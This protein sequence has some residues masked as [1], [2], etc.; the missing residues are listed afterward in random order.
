MADLGCQFI[1]IPGLLVLP[2][3]F[4][5]S[6]T[7]KSRPTTPRSLE[8]ACKLQMN[9]ATRQMDSLERGAHRSL[10]EPKVVTGKPIQ[11]VCWP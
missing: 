8:T 2:S 5:L 10:S 7:A 9:F 3:S 1:L 11:S 4:G 6:A